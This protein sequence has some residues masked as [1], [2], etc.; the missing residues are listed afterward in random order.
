MRSTLTSVIVSALSAV[1]LALAFPKAGQA[2]LAPLAAAGLFWAWQRLSWKRAFFAGWFAGTI[3]FAINFSWFTYTVGSYVGAFAFAVVLIPALVEGLTFAASALATRA[4]DRWGAPWAAPA[5]AAAAFTVF[6]WLRSIGLLAVPFAQIGYSQTVTPLIAFAPYIGAFGVTF[7]VMLLGA[8]GAQAIAN[9]DPRR[10]AIVVT[11][12]IAAWAICFAAWP[13][14][15]D[16]RVPIL[17]VSAVQGNIAQTVKWNPQSFWPTVNTYL[18][19]TRQLQNLHPQLVVLPETVIPTDLNASDP[20]GVRA[21]VRNDFSAAARTL[22]ATLVIGSLEARG[23]KDYNALF[24]FNPSGTISQIYEKRQLV[25]FTES[26]P[27]QAFLG[28]LPDSDLIGR[29][30]AGSDDTVISAAGV[31]FAP[32]ICW[33]SAFADLVHAQVARGAQFLV[34]S[35]DDAWFGETSGTFQHAQIAQMRAVENGQWVL[36]S[37]ATGISGIIAPDGTWMQQTALDRPALVTGTIGAPPGSIFAHIGPTPILVVLALMYGAVFAL[38]KVRVRAMQWRA[39]RSRVIVLLAGA[40]VLIW[41]VV[42]VVLAGNAPGGPPQGLTPLTLHG[43]R[44]TGNRMSTKSWMFEYDHAEMSPDGVLA[45]VQGVRRGVLYKSGKPYLSV[46]AE[47]VSVNTQTFDFTATGDVHVTQMQ[48]AS[49]ER[50]FDTDLIQWL[51]A[52]KTLS[53]PHPSVVRSGGETLRVS[54]INVNFNS[55]QIR[56]GGMSG[57]VAP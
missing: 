32:L 15:H 53:L 57:G 13:A 18:A 33:E 44:V 24:V 17:R 9:R 43:G 27:G 47:Q 25:P 1:A 8:Y 56:F 48:D 14:R 35:T 20:N 16:P 51:N 40:A 3:F 28:W 45:T 5:A 11:V 21:L 55:G 34:I 49:S 23:P 31:P 41:I 4:A 36:Q 30:A 46:R 26:F 42:E 10:L 22:D 38:R 12:V 6:E 19:Q 7:V 2:W 50:S 29:F 39:P 54:S 37:A 52:A